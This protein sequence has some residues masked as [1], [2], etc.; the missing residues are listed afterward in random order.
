MRPLATSHAC[1]AS[2]SATAAAGGGGGG[3]AGRLF[4]SFSGVGS[5]D[6]AG[7]TN[8]LSILPRPLRGVESLLGDERYASKA[9]SEFIIASNCN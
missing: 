3:E 6:S 9:L 5:A 8:L 1:A 7:L 2:S 4:V